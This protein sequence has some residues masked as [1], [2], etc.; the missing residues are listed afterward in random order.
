MSRQDEVRTPPLQHFGIGALLIGVIAAELLTPL[1]LAVWVFYALPLGMCLFT[2]SPMLP[3]FVAALATVV[4]ALS[5]VLDPLRSV[6]LV[7]NWLGLA[8][9]SMY[10]ATLWPVALMVR[11]LMI[12][13]EDSEREA[14]LRRTQATLLE[15]LQGELPVGEVVKRTLDG[16]VRAV[17]AQVGAAFLVQRDGALEFAA[18]YALDDD[19]T[20][21]AFRAG[22]GLVGAAAENG[23]I[24]IV[25]EVPEGFLRVHAGIGSGAPR[26]VTIAPL[27]TETRTLAVLAL[28]T[29]GKATETDRALLERI[30]E[31]TAIAI[32]SAEYQKR[33]RELLDE[34]Q[35]QAH[36][37]QSQQAELEAQQAE[38]EAAN[39][40]LAQTNAT[41]EIQS[42]ELERQRDEVA[43]ARDA[44]EQAS[45]YKSE[46]L[47]NM[48]HELRTPLN[49][50]LI[51][52]RLLADNAEGNLNEEQ[53]RSA[54]TIY[55][56]GNDLLV[57]INDILDLAKIESGH[58]DVSAEPVSLANVQDSL[59]RSFRALATQR[60]LTFRIDLSAELEPTLQ[61]DSRR[62]EQILKNLLA[63]AFKFTEAGSVELLI[64][65]GAAGRIRFSVRDT[66]LG[67]APD[68]QEVIFE[69]F[70]Q[71]DGTTSRKHGGTGLGLSISRE[72]ARL[73]GGDISV[74]SSLGKGSTFTLE[75]PL[76]GTLPEPAQAPLPA[77]AAWAS[78]ERVS[79]RAEPKAPSQRT[80]AFSDDREGPRQRGRLI[81]VVE[82]DAA[83][84]RILYDLAHELDFDCAVAH[85]AEEGLALASELQPSGILLDVGLPDASGLSVLERL[86]RN[87][88]TRHVPIHMISAADNVQTA[89]ELGA[90]GY[91]LKPVAR[92][93]LVT[94]LK[95]LEERY[96]R[97][98]RRVLLVEDD[99]RQ[100]ES[101]KLLLG[102][103]G[104]ELVVAGSVKEAL[105]E[106][107]RR[108][109]DCMVLDLTLPDGSGHDLLEKMAEGIRYSFPPVIVY[110]GKDLERADEEKLRKYSRSIIVKGARSPERLLDEV[111]LFLHRVESTLPPDHRRMLADVRQRDTAFEG[112]T[113]LVVEDD[114]RNV[115]A[116]SRVLEPRGATVLIARNGREALEVLDREPSVDLVL[117]DL[118]MP[119]MDGLTATRELRKRERLKQLPVIALTAKAMADDREQALGAGANDY[120]AKPFEVER[121][122]SLC[123][124]WLPR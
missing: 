11:K 78:P 104:V 48:S 112:R 100:Q 21:L 49:S 42:E 5:S 71:A 19:D 72:L 3:L 119:E 63:N 65:R 110:T 117:M 64:T 85:T 102:G 67:I 26:S 116:L 59:E 113:I 22:E 94:A 36:E 76:E 81:L 107:E 32:R 9:R 30:S 121:L 41:M 84:A 8:N 88:A 37:L 27:R 80:P 105:P 38:L 28:G 60:N 79:V 51:L 69:A 57:L 98:V 14:W 15:S 97:E 12:A 95:K 2:R 45:Q 7:E 124:V 92:E 24:T 73:L 101:L 47:A 111:T 1:G 44:A 123:R 62:L 16:V 17:N 86:K 56:A 23:R 115:F 114:V 46:F 75:L 25:P 68:Q 77:K 43:A 29:M 108:S 122:V 39:E 10:I 58:A 6:S 109:F 13:R 83:F 120:M 103:I 31:P 33:L 74:E 55:S 50:S 90:I 18:G 89:L 34:S 66:G 99:P 96:E 40:E 106:L 52:A 61:T 91:A 4:T 118:M 82:D 87:P 20:K 35:R 70:R 54:E 53:V 93:D